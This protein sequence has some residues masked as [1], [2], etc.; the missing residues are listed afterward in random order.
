M[1]REKYCEIRAQIYLNKHVPAAQTMDFLTKND[2]R[3]HSE[4]ALQWL[5]RCLE[6]TGNQGF[7]HSFSPIFGW[8]EAYPETTGYLLETFFDYSRHHAD[9][10]LAATAHGQAAW[11]CRLQMP[12]GAFPGG[13]LA[14]EPRPSAFN[15]GQILLGLC[16]AATETH[17]VSE[18]KT[19]L[20]AAEK[21]ADWLAEIT[22]PDGSWAEGLYVENFCPTY[23]VRAVWGMLEANVFLK[24]PAIEAAARRALSFYEK[25]LTAANSFKNCGFYPNKPAFTHTIAYA[26][27]G[28][29]ECGVLLNEEKYVKIARLVLDEIIEKSDPKSTGDFETA[30]EFDE[31]WRGNFRFKCITGNCQL[32]L[33]SSRFFELTGNEKYRRA[34]IGFLSEII[35]CQRLDGNP[36]VF[37]A[38]PGSAP[39][40]GKYMRMRYPNWAAKFFLDAL[41]KLSPDEK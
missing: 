7:S 31:N 40:Y 27:R 14:D 41:L 17:S 24:K 22:L 28:F 4:A 11:L 18:Q 26:I 23:H 30:G 6:M 38:L 20:A 10:S 1:R 2:H 36:D 32:S 25:N 33:N 8:K 29:L 19:L 39:F 35:D 12:N 3:R 34:A 15:T 5:R 9:P 13:T 21:A 16:R 37:G